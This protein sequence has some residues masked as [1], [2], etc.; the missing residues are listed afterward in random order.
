M[1]KQ[2]LHLFT[3][4]RHKHVGWPV[5]RTTDSL[6]FQS[7][8]DCGARRVYLMQPAIKIGPWISK[9]QPEA[10]SGPSCSDGDL[11]LLGVASLEAVEKVM[12]GYEREFSDRSR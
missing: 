11:P 3:N 10:P 5:R 8:M 9:T 12:S 4:C 7:C 6:S 2:L 1:F